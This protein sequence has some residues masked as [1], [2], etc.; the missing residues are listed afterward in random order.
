MSPRTDR[1]TS[2]ARERGKHLVASGTERVASGTERMARSL[3][4][5]SKAL[6][7]VGTALAI[8]GVG[9]ATGAATAGAATTSHTASKSLARKSPAAAS[10]PAA[11]AAVAALPSLAELTSVL[12]K[13]P[14]S[15]VLPHARL[16]AA[17]PAPSQPKVITRAATTAHPAAA[18][19]GR[20]TKNPATKSPATASAA[21]ATGAVAAL[22][23]LAELT[24][25]TH[26][27]PV[28]PALPHPQQAAASPAPSQP[29][30]ITW[31][32]VQQA[33]YQPPKPAAPQAGQLPADQL[34]PT[35]TSGPQSW[36]PISPAQM[37]NASAI[38]QQALN[39]KM[40]IRSAVIAV[41]TAMQES[42]LLN[43]HYGDL[44]S[45]GLFQQRP[46]M[47]WG[48]AA[49]ITTPSFA[50]GAFLTALQHYQAGDPTWASQPLWA[51]AQ[52]VQ[53]SGFPFAYAKWESQAAG[54]VKQIATRL[55]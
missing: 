22:P 9:S 29:K 26:E 20:A 4:G 50:A 35:G 40:G 44:D 32:Q 24:S 19:S 51:N 43:L 47:G 55:V 15:P 1:L 41:A 3:R 48:T 36:M 14:V 12:H 31:S 49:Q 25:V 10:A 16:A 39:K 7:Y 21:T 5:R 45:L 52:A 53:K 28:T 8:A 23:S 38:V 33:F 6:A 34:T 30:V 17:S 46:S 27:L 37:S 2:A 13:L 18:T 54:L 42:Q 11:A